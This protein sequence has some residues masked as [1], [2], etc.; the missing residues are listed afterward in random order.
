MHIGRPSRADRIHA[1]R[2]TGSPAAAVAIAASM[3]DRSAAECANQGR[4]MKR[5]PT[6]CSRRRPLA[7]SGA[8]LTSTTTPPTEN[9]PTNVKIESITRRRRLS[10]ATTRSNVAGLEK[11][12]R[13]PQ[14]ARPDVL[15]LVDEA[16]HA[17]HPWLAQPLFFDEQNPKNRIALFHPLTSPRVRVTMA[18]GRDGVNRPAEHFG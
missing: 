8:W 15:R 18:R 10:S 4:S 9:S 17:I 3:R 12:A 6:T 1:S 11:R 14:R 5:C 13:F 7:V 2:R 16:E